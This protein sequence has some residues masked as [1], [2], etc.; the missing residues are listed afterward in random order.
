MGLVASYNFVERVVG[1]YMYEWSWER[2]LMD[3]GEYL[4]ELSWEGPLVLYIYLS[5]W[6]E[7]HQSVAVAKGKASVSWQL[8]G[9]PRVQRWRMVWVSN[10]IQLT[11]TIKG[12]FGWLNLLCPH[13]CLCYQ[14]PIQC[15]QKCTSNFS[16]HC[17]SLSLSHTHKHTPQLVFSKIWKYWHPPISCQVCKILKLC[18]G[19]S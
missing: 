1:G 3:C 14:L 9:R 18:L 11:V 7:G 19:L 12:E 15:L 10:A 17:S 2:I 4:S 13:T 8:Y 16:N 5:G 6:C